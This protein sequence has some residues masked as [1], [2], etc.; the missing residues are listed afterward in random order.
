MSDETWTCDVCY[1]DGLSDALI[2]CL[3]GTPR[4]L[5]DNLIYRRTKCLDSKVYIL[6]SYLLDDLIEMILSYLR[7]D[8]K[9][10][11][12]FTINK[13]NYFQGDNIENYLRINSL[14]YKSNK[15]RNLLVCRSILYNSIRK[16]TEVVSYEVSNPLK[17][18]NRLKNKIIIYDDMLYIK[19]DNNIFFSK[20]DY[21]YVHYPIRI[22]SS[23]T[24]IIEYHFYNNKLY[25]SCADSHIYE[26]YK[27][28][29]NM[30]CEMDNPTRNDFCI[31]DNY[32]YITDLYNSSKKIIMI[33]ITNKK[34]KYVIN[35]NNIKFNTDLI[36][37]IAVNKYRI[38]LYIGYNVYC[39]NY[40][41]KITQK[42]DVS[43]KSHKINVKYNKRINVDN[44]KI[45]LLVKNN[46]HIYSEV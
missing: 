7:K 13:N 32:I 42:I 19:Q 2:S 38:F 9:L 44:K 39:I 40:Y 33:K 21:E 29:T 35:L 46:V 25:F 6:R 28:K 41:G 34:I 23:E 5:K 27:L 31:Y 11:R 15:I 36:C 4:N 20:I 37:S 43:P 26:Y 1:L 45:Y 30:F 10:I 12:T 14:R 3:C 16:Q 18:I 22:V 8:Y 24:E 17:E